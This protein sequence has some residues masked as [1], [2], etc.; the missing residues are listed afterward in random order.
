MDTKL[1]VRSPNHNRHRSLGGLA[2]AWIEHFC[3]H[4]P[5]DVQGK[6]I[7]LDDEFAGFIYD[8]YAVNEQGRRLY[9]T[10]FLSR[11]KGRAKSE[12]AGFLV[13][14]EAFGPARFAGFAQGGEVFRIG[15]FS[16]TYSAGEPMGRP[17][18]YA[19]IRCLATEETQAGNT[20]DNVYY[21]LGG[22]G[23]GSRRLIETY[24]VN[25]NSVGL[26]KIQLPDGGEIVPSTASSSAKDGGKETFAV[27]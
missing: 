21:N 12:L 13:L 9:R 3:V 11:A 4:G 14:F 27:F 10:A 2:I 16:Y 7:L 22:Y 5:G 19:F 6:P 23:E 17:V 26:T 15:S 20:Y 8:A 1:L 25:K 18:T 24:G